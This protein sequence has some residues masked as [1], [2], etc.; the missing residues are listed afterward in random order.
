MDIITATVHGGRTEVELRKLS[1]LHK[2]P[3]NSPWASTN[4]KRSAAQRLP[5]YSTTDVDQFHIASYLEQ[6]PF[7]GKTKHEFLLYSCVRKV[8]S[9]TI[10]LA[11]CTGVYT[12][13]HNRI[14]NFLSILKCST[15]RLQD[16]LTG[17]SPEV[18]GCP[19]VSLVLCYW[20]YVMHGRPDF[21]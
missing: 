8:N 2:S 7:F 5:G 17:R 3:E 12:I 15:W 11:Y 13:Y 10:Y 1:V 16:L 20:H 6:A 18:S 14:R 9:H 19:F 21:I 4:V